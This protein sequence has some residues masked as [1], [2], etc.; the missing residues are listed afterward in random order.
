MARTKKIEEKCS[1]D[2]EMLMWTSYRYCI[3]RRTYV[4]EMAYYIAQKY[5]PILSDERR[6]FTADDI[7]R[8]IFDKLKWV[9]PNYEIHRFYSEEPF[10]PL[11]NLFEFINRENINSVEEFITYANINYD[12]PKDKFTFDKCTPNVRKYVNTSDFEDLIPW[13]DLA[14]C[15][16]TK[17]HKIAELN[18]GTEVEVFPSW[19]RKSVKME[20][21]DMYRITSFGWEPIWKS[22]N[23]FIRKGRNMYYIP[24]K[25][26][27]EFKDI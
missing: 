20:D 1:L 2:E 23:D 22:V 15:F 12:V 21:S 14:N 8:E 4:T 27:K 19:Q 17:C 7:R 3:G 26:I 25:N 16:D 18:D 13:M 24:L 11:E 6:L 9:V 5:Y 10:H